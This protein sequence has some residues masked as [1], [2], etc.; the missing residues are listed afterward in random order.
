MTTIVTNPKITWGPRVD[1]RDLPNLY[2][3]QTV[4]PY[5]PP[6]PGIDNLGISSTDTF[7]IPGK[8][9]FKVDFQGYVRVARSQP[10]TDQWLDSEVYTN[11]IEMCMR[12]EAPEIGQI[13]VTLN[14]DILSTGMLRTPWADMNCEQPEK[15]CRMAVAALFTLPQLGM[16]LFNKEPIELTIDHVQAIPPAG[17][18]GEG[19]IYQVLPLFDLANPDS[20][21]A[22]YLTGLKFAMGNYVTEAQL[23]SIASE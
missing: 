23:Q 6:P 19:R 15:A 3:P 4:D 18:P 14:P 2:A 22:A 13:V 8:G 21:P 17:N 12:G 5:T 9:E 11:L 10:S 20:K 1:L 16:T 7:M